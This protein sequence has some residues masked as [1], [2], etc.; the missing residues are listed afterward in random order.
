MEKR[1]TVE[2]VLSVLDG[3][4][5]PL[6]PTIA[7]LCENKSFREGM[8]AGLKM[9]GFIQACAVIDLDVDLALEAY[10]K[11][12]ELSNEQKLLMIELQQTLNI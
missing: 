5:L 8:E 7:E 1:Y 10:F 4:E 11:H 9:A 3:I 6:K 2:E 12:L